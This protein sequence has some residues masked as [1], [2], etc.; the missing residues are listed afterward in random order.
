MKTKAAFILTHKQAEVI[1][2]FSH[3]LYHSQ[4]FYVTRHK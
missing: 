4:S 3:R 1:I 2:Y